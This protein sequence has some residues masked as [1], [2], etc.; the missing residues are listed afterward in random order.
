LEEAEAVEERRAPDGGW[1]RVR[2]K[3]RVWAERHVKL[4]ID[5]VPGE[6]TR[7]REREERERAQREWERRNPEAAERRRQRRELA[8][9]SL[10]PVWEDLR[11]A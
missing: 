8:E 1:R 3:K 5:T 6:A 2:V 11:D 7:K 10:H 9:M 4:R